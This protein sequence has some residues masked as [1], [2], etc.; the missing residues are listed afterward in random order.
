MSR[1]QTFGAGRTHSIFI[2]EAGCAWACGWNDYGQLGLGDTIQ[3]NQPE[4]IENLP[5]IT[6]VSVGGYYSMFLDIEGNVWACGYNLDGQLGLG[7]GD[8]NFINVPERITNLPKIQ[9]I[10]CSFHK[11]SLFLDEDGC[12]WACGHNTHGELGLGDH[13]NR[14]HPV[15]IYEI[16]RMQSISAGY[17]HS[18]FLDGDGCVWTC[19]YNHHGQLGLG[20]KISRNIPERIEDFGNI[21]S[22]DGVFHS[23]FLDEEGSVWV[24]G[25]NDYGQLG[26]EN[27]SNRLLPERIAQLPKI[28]S[29][30]AGG[31]HSIFLD[32][33]GCVWS[34]GNNSAGQLGMGESSFKL[35]FTQRN[36]PSKVNISK[37]KSISAGFSHSIF[38]DEV[39]QVWACGH[40]QY[41]QL[42]LG[43]F[44]QMDHPEKIDNLPKIVSL[45]IEKRGLRVKSARN[46][47]VL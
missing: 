15:R 28:Q 45:N 37:Q 2:D 30:F 21:K 1:Q 11:H 7:L 13:E 10:S 4:K 33:D 26:L 25:H 42:G 9:A 5:F 47:S 16:P 6:S 12:V 46:V 29:I 44:A 27:I 20:H 38:L 14:A 31:Y 36:S 24:C 43:H 3:R 34:C 8:R 22:I 35:H 17:C 23:I 19:G 41:G 40:N 32:E 39:G 18:L